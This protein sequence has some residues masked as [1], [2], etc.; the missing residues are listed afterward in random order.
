MYFRNF[1][2]IFTVILNIL[3]PYVYFSTMLLSILNPYVS[4]IP[5]NTYGLYS[6]FL[7]MCS[8]A[9]YTTYN[10]TLNWLSHYVGLSTMST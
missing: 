3:C 10:W 1:D 4:Y 5:T 8:D 7:Y 9:Y 2:T 6:L